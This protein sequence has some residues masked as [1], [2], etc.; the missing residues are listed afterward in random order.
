MTSTDR[1]GGTLRHFALLG[2][3]DRRGAW[4]VPDDLLAVSAVGGVHLDLTEA[5]LPPVLT[6]TKVSLVG[7]VKVRV[8]AD[9][10]VDTTGFALVGHIGS[11]PEAVPSDREAPI[12]R[13]RAYGVFGGVKV[14]RA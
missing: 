9:A 14:T 5:K 11:V 13:V 2:G 8:P 7:G 1:S 10:R 3:L 12:V 4:A 6:V